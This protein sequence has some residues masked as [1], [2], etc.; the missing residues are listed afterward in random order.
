MWK[1]KQEHTESEIL[2]THF[3]NNVEN[4]ILCKKIKIR[5]ISSAMK[6][7]TC[8]PQMFFHEDTHRH[9]HPHP[10]RT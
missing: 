1:M 3:W 10:R 8:K 2:L 9:H 4:E 5:A 6:N 7:K